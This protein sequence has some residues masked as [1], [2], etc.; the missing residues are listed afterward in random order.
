MKRPETYFCDICGKDII[1]GFPHTNVLVNTDCDWTEGRYE[2][3]HL[4]YQTMDICTDCMFK[5]TS[6]YCGFQ[7]SN[8][9]IKFDSG[10]D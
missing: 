2:K 8:P 4:K 1:T 7:G 6:I 9:V 3:T 5:A 10:G